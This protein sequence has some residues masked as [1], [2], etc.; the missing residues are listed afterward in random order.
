MDIRVFAHPSTILIAGPTGSGKTRFISAVL[1]TRLIHPF[2]SRIV[3]VYSEWQPAYQ[4]LQSHFPDIEF[5][6]GWSDEIYNLFPEYVSS[7]K[8]T[9]NLLIL[10]DIMTSAHNSKI[11]KDLFTK[12]SHHRDLTVIYL[13]QN[14][15]DQ[16]SAMRTV[17]LNAQYIVLFRNNRD[18]SQV[19]YLAQQVAPNNMRFIMDV[20]EDATRNAFGY[21]IFDFR[22][23]TRDELRIKTGIL[24]GEKFFGYVEQRGL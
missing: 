20:Y 5:I 13:V 17:S 18:K 15:F 24:P 8:S 1:E 23:S 6:Q 22:P 16:G 11:L 2:P 7:H 14:L 21:V 3:Y 4:Q 12:G 9:R 19:R 10:D